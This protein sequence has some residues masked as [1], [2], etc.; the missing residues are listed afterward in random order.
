MSKLNNY[1]FYD[2]KFFCICHRCRWHRWQTLS[3]EYL[4][5]FSKKFETTLIVYSGAWG[6]L[7]HEKNQKSK[8][9]WHCPFKSFP[10]CFSQSPLPTDLLPPQLWGKVVC[11]WFVCKH[12]IRTPLKSEHCQDYGQKPQRN[13]T[14]MNSASG[15]EYFAPQKNSLS[16]L[17]TPVAACR[18]SF[19]ILLASSAETFILLINA[20]SHGKGWTY[21]VNQCFLYFAIGIAGQCRTNP[22]PVV[23]D[24]TRMPECRCRTEA[25]FGQC[26]LLTEDIKKSTL[27]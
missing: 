13:G 4:H 2:L 18:T 12:Y 16:P 27:T 21:I 23:P 17:M 8:I 24:W 1:N 11:N 5:E 26:K 7:I 22:W 6:K 3:W 25:A 15:L 19:Q 10:P 9:S 14:F 20:R